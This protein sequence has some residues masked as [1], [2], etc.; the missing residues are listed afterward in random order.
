M[1]K[2]LVNQ[3]AEGEDEDDEPTNDPDAEGTEIRSDKFY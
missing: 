2:I 1:V 3:D